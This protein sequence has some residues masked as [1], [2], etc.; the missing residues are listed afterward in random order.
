MIETSLL[1]EAQLLGWALFA[2]SLAAVLRGLFRE[3]APFLPAAGNQHLW[4]GSIV[5]CAFIWG[6]QVRALRGLEVGLLASP[7]VALLFGR[8]RAMLAL[9]AAL[10]LHTV[11]AGRGWAGFGLAALQLVVLPVW[12]A[13]ALQG[14]IARR[15][16]R[17]VFIFLL[18]NGLFVV[19]VTA[20]VTALVRIAVALALA[21]PGADLQAGDATAYALLLAWGEALASGMIFS[22]IVI[23]RPHLVL[24]YD[25][26]AYLPRRGARPTDPRA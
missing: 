10:A 16:P 11:L 22:A 14:Q 13:T 18:G 24:T 26:D 3:R 17:N 15:L 21:P 19:L 1:A 6:L 20:A 5:I 4:L 7:L 8:A 2:A 9:T 25:Q 12:L 23:Y